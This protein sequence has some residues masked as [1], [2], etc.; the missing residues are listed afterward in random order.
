MLLF[1]RFFNYAAR[2][3]RW[4]PLHCVC[5]TDLTHLTGLDSVLSTYSSSP[6]SF[7]LSLEDV[8]SDGE[9]NQAIFDSIGL[10]PAIQ[11]FVVASTFIAF[12]GFSS[13]MST[14][15]H[16]SAL[17][18]SSGS[19]YLKIASTNWS[20]CDS[21]IFVGMPRGFGRVKTLIDAVSVT[22]KEI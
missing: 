1:L 9:V 14:S 6:S 19:S 20:T 18:I 12:R 2:I 16:P 11:F 13:L 15:S 5:E 7:Q 21:I 3:I 4:S 8:I 10:P 17:L 22:A